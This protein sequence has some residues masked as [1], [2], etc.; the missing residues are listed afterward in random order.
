MIGCSTASDDSIPSLHQFDKSATLPVSSTPQREIICFFF[1][2]QLTPT[3]I[4]QCKSSMHVERFHEILSLQPPEEGNLPMRNYVTRRQNRECIARVK[5][6]LNVP[7]RGQLASNNSACRFWRIT[8]KKCHRQT[9]YRGCEYHD[10]NVVYR[11]T[12]TLDDGVTPETE[13]ACQRV[14]EP[15]RRVAIVK[16]S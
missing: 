9:I 13:R 8:S 10:L 2:Y 14:R 6:A 12:D 3:C 7:Y 16:W 15:P 1:I 4:C 5:S 11:N